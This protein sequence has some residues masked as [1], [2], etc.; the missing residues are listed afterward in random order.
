M[1]SHQGTSLVQP[2]NSEGLAK[3]PPHPEKDSPQVLYWGPLKWGRLGQ[4][5]FQMKMSVIL[6]ASSIHVLMLLENRIVFSGK[7][8]T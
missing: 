6:K 5:F 2:F 7:S 1:A 8:H 4:S 3:E